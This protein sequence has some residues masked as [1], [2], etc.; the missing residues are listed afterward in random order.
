MTAKSV[1]FRTSSA[2]RSILKGAA[3]TVGSCRITKSPSEVGKIPGMD[4]LIISFGESA[5][6]TI[7]LLP[8]VAEAPEQ[9]PLL[10]QSLTIATV[11]NRVRASPS[12]FDELDGDAVRMTNPHTSV[13]N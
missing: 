7:F 3:L 8:K 1:A 10:S 13:H 5:T 2:N 9:D 6:T 4:T 11:P 12:V